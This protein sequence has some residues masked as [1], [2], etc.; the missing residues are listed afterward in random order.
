MK[1]GKGL[2]RRKAKQGPRKD[3]R[4]GGGYDPSAIQKFDVDQIQSF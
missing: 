4:K 3:R 2:K 1:N